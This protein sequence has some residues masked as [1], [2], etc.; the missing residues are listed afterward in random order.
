MTKTLAVSVLA[1]AILTSDAHTA[2]GVFF[3]EYWGEW[4]ERISNHP[5]RLRV[6]DTEI[7]LHPS[8]GRRSEGKANG[9][10]L[11]TVPEDIFTL[12]RA[13]LYLELWGGHPG[14]ARK[15]FILNGKGT[16]SL[17]EV[18]TER[19]HCTYSYPVIPLERVHL[20]SGVNAFQFA[21]DRGE[22]F[23]GHFIIDNACVRAHLQADHPDLVAAGLDAFSAHIGT[24]AEGAAIGDACR[25][26]LEYPEELAGGIVSVDYFAR[27]TGFDDDGDGEDA[28]WH[29]FTQ[30]R[31]PREHLGSAT[32]PPFAVTWDT[33][34]IPT[35]GGPMGL[36]AVVHLRDG[37]QYATPVVDGLTFAERRRPVVLFRASEL[38]APFWSRASRERT[39][40]VDLPEDLSAVERAELY[41]K[42]WDGGEGNVQEPFTLNGHPYGVT[43]G[44]ASHD[45]VFTKVEV[46]GDH[47]KPG[48]NEFRLLS[49]TQHHGVEVLLPGPCLI[50]RF[51]Q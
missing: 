17:P 21:C 32:G 47:L 23:W 42:V 49:D 40:T 31:E 16:Y 24:P 28:G 15:R 14:T 3:R 46:K 33:S 11:L 43:S 1:A 37:F 6:N 25:V 48:A 19:K 45:V 22:T 20:V 44:R 38:P 12:E 34:M 10:M 9:L 18:G 13:E 7:T 2:Q 35:Q 30:K 4:D 39:A 36:R 51:E 50:L 29:G 26:A 8:Y 27:Y 5:G 41:V